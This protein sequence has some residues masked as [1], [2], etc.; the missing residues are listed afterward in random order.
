MSIIGDQRV[1]TWLS[2]LVLIDYQD[3]QSL[4]SVETSNYFVLC[5]R[6]DERAL[7]SICLSHY[8]DWLDRWR[9]FPSEVD[10]SDLIA[11]TYD[12]LGVE[13]ACS[14]DIEL[15]NTNLAAINTTLGEMRDRLGDSQA[16]LDTKL[17]DIKASIDALETTL[18]AI[19]P[20]LI[21]Q[22]E[23]IL[24]GVGVILGAPSISVNGS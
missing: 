10:R 9:N 24:N 2:K 14:E 21:D 16:D 12:S 13:L 15:L 22:L 8:V 6:P 4:T 7:L 19:D 17:A 23:T 20:S 5:I 11:R 18:A 3:I 1:T